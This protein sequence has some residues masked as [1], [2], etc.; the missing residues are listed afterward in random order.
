MT[1]YC[2]LAEVR[3]ELKAE[4]TVNDAKL[5]ENVRTV[6]RRLDAVLFQKRPL[7][8]PWIESR[9][10]L[11]ESDA[12]NSYWN[13]IQ[14]GG[15]LLDASAVTR[16]TTSL[17]I[18]T[19][20]ETWPTLASPSNMLR[21][22]SLS[23]SWYSNCDACGSNPLF[24]TI[25]G[26]WGWNRDYANAWL[27][28]DDLAADIT[29]SATTLTVADIDGAD[30]Y[31][32]IPRISAGNLL[33]IGTE[34]IEVMSTVTGTNTATVKRGVN[35]STAAAHVSGADVEVWQ[36]EEIV[37][38]ATVRQSAFL[39]A[40]RGSYESSSINDVGIVNFPADL[41]GEI[42]GIIQNLAYG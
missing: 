10:T 35:G 42:R 19:D 21:L 26:I 17:V 6:S 5:L 9:Q 24:V 37:K 14:F 3:G 1:L 30:P 38:R 4:N 16:G 13:T 15:Y 32:R 2:T 20:V 34:F 18:G 12:V 40:R 33:R 23:S 27:K 28:V 29:A 8:A 31:G 7:F 41:L 36:V 22:K 11:V 39:Y 25:D